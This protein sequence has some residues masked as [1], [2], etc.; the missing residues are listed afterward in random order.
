M[1]EQP[2]D[3][4]PVL[5][6]ELHAYVDNALEPAHRSE[7]EAYLALHPEAA[8]EVAAFS[9]HRQALRDM[10]SPIVKEPLPSSLNLARMLDLHQTR[11]RWP[12]P[13]GMAAA[14]VLALGIGGTT[15]WSLRDGVP[16]GT[17]AGI[18]ALAREAS[19]SYQVYAAD[20]LRPV[21]MG[22][23]QRAEL[24]EWVSSRLGRKVA[25]PDLA[26]AGYRFIGG[27]LV[28]TEHGPAGLFM[29]DDP[30]GVRLSLLVRPMAV[31]KDTPM[32]KH[33]QGKFTG[34]AWADQ[35]LGYGVVGTKRA[36]V[37]HPLADEIRR[38]ISLDL[39]G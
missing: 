7:V 16:Y 2:V 36:E 8:A 15:G 26:P 25:I 29:Y 10:L 14:V 38:Q 39:K 3:M 32:M 34:Y 1:S 37:L 23:S 13:W 35:G 31:D 21:E 20:T 5:E 17:D 30:Q 27:R 12:W 6:E 19:S 22:A 4:R 11:P 9:A 28:A 33:I 24:V 18:A